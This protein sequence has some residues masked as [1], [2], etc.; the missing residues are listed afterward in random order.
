MLLMS[1]SPS[2]AHDFQFFPNTEHPTDTSLVAVA[3]ET[4]VGAI[5]RDGSTNA[6]PKIQQAIDTLR[7]LGGGILYLRAGRYRCDS[8]LTLHEGVCLRGDWTSPLTSPAIGGTILEIEGTA[9]NGAGAVTGAPFV[10]LRCS[11]SVDGVHFHYPNQKPSATFATPYPPTIRVV[12][13]AS[14]SRH[15]ASVRNITLV[16]SYIGVE[17]GL[18]NH[19]LPIFFN[20]HGSPLRTGLIVDN[21]TDVHRAEQIHFY[22]SVWTQ[23]GLSSNPGGSSAHA[24]YIKANATG[25]L[26]RWSDNG[27]IANSSIRGYW[28]GL[29]FATSLADP[30][31]RDMGG[32]AYGL[33]IS[34]CETAVYATDVHPAAVCISDSVLAGDTLAVSTQAE[35]GEAFTGRLQFLDTTFTSRGTVGVSLAGGDGAAYLSFQSCVFNDRVEASSGNLTLLDNQFPFAA[36]PT[37]PHV[38]LSSAIARAALVA[39]TNDATPVTVN[40]AAVASKVRINNANDTYLASPPRMRDSLIVARNVPARFY[41]PT[42]NNY[43]PS[44]QALANGSD[45]VNDRP[46]IQSALD[47]AGADGGGVVFLPP[48]RYVLNA[49]LSLPAS[50]EL[51]GA[52]DFPFHSKIALLDANQRGTRLDVNHGAGGTGSPAFALGANAILRGIAVHYPDQTFN[53]R[54]VLAYPP[55]IRVDGADATVRHVVSHNAYRLVDANRDAADGLLLSFLMGYA[56]NQGVA[57]GNNAINARLHNVHLNP[58]FWVQSTGGSNNSLP[59]PA[60]FADSAAF[61]A[62]LA[63]YATDPAYGSDAFWLGNTSGLRG[64]GNFAITF[65]Y[66]VRHLV[67]SGGS[68]PSGTFAVF[69]VDDAGVALRHEG[70][71]MNYVSASLINKIDGEQI[72]LDTPDNTSGGSVVLANLRVLGQHS[73]PVRHRSAAS[74]TVASATFWGE[75]A[76]QTIQTRRGPLFLWNALYRNPVAFSLPSTG[77]DIECAASIFRGGYT[78]A[79]AP[80]NFSVIRVFP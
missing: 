77:G 7:S 62:A 51:R 6:R 37:A 20:I 79:T 57:L 69:G 67:Q 25:L 2:F 13:S 16:N 5:A 8:P 14:I 58:H 68:G 71:A 27:F 4:L 1:V 35:A 55:M 73:L 31:G 33:D 12:P 53:Q 80:A 59:I 52:L 74:L 64:L 29:W 61:D 42:V 75:T 47:R 34:D 39:N 9:A 11:A 50:V 38:R 65:R 21:C 72:I 17:S 3:A 36:T 22:P 28:R 78:P 49:G 70:G 60:G 41:D 24:T 43:G 32:L 48:G 45:S 23:C 56:L 19:A 26:M 66:G 63:T 30:N 10:T 15:C 44:G 18:D 54:A 46:A 76:K 40:N